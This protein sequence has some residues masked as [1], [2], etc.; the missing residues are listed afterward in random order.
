MADA[1]MEAELQGSQA[2][3]ERSC[4]NASQAVDGCLETV[5]EKIFALGADQ[6]RPS[7]EAMCQMFFKDSGSFLRRCHE[8][9]QERR[10]KK[11]KSIG[12]PVSRWFYQCQGSTMKAL[13]KSLVEFDLAWSRVTHGERG[14]AGNFGASN[15]RKRTLSNSPSRER[16]PMEEDASF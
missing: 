6:A 1:G 5:V 14:R 11:S 2:G 12:N 15:V 13:Q 7:F 16:L 9:K 3:G 10:V 4:S 8:K